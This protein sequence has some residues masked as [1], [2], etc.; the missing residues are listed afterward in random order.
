MCRPSPPTSPSLDSLLF[1][2]DINV[3]RGDSNIGG[4]ARP[5]VARHPAPRGPQYH[6]FYL[7]NMAI[8]PSTLPTITFN[9][10]IILARRLIPNLRVSY[11][12]RLYDSKS[13]S[14]PLLITPA[15]RSR[16]FAR[17]MSQIIA[18][19]ITRET[20]IADNLTKIAVELP[21]M[22][23]FGDDGETVKEVPVPAS[24]KATGT[25]PEGFTIGI[26]FSQTG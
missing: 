7:S 24:I 23:V 16:E 13:T 15:S 20:F 22:F 26:V 19:T 12:K 9:S 4:C 5:Q 6:Q 2:S 25:L 17:P 18:R 1:V 10:L 3:S 14:T 21:T 8:L 11:R